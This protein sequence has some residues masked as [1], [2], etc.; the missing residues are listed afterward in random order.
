M[1]SKIPAF[2]AT[3]PPG[4]GV[5]SIQLLLTDMEQRFPP[6]EAHQTSRRPAKSTRWQLRTRDYKRQQ[7]LQS[8]RNSGEQAAFCL[9][10]KQTYQKCTTS[11]A[12]STRLEI[13]ANNESCC[14][15]GSLFF[16]SFLHQ[17]S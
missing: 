10:W 8:R 5:A 17:Y 3:A 4:G 6:H 9:M 1:Y 2:K 7:V 12:V 13:I 14:A 16:L 11:P 15:G